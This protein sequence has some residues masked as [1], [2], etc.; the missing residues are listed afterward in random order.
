L[1]DE[2]EAVAEQ[3]DAPANESP[4][5]GEE[6]GAPPRPVAEDE[7]ARIAPAS[8]AWFLGSVL[9]IILSVIIYAPII[10]DGW[11]RYDNVPLIAREPMIRNLTIGG[12]REMFTSYHHDLYQPLLTLSLAIDYALNRRDANAYPDA[13]L[14]ASDLT[15]WHLHSLAIH[16]TTVVLLF[17]FIGRMTGN[18]FAAWLGTALFALHPLVVE[19]VSWLICRTFL[20]AGFWIILGCHFYLSYA[21][22]PRWWLYVLSFLC[23]GISMLAKLF[24]GIFLLPLV[25]DLWY[26]RRN[27]ILIVLDKL[28][29][30]ALVAVLVYF[31]ARR[32]FSAE[33]LDQ[34]P[35]VSI[36][37]MI[38]RVLVGMSWAEAHTFFPH[39]L[40]VFYGASGS[41]W[42]A[43]P[44]TTVFGLIM[45][46]AM[47]VITVVALVRKR[48]EVLLCVFGWLVLYVPLLAAVRV[49][50]TITADRYDYVP[51][52]MCALLV[53][54]LLS[55]WFNPPEQ[56]ET[57]KLSEARIFPR[58]PGG[59]IATV[60]I[61]VIC[62][63]LLTRSRAYAKVWSDDVLLWEAAVA[64][65]PHRTAYG[66]LANA[67]ITKA[68][69]DRRE[70][71][72][73]A[74][75][76]LLDRAEVALR[77]GLE[78]SPEDGQLLENYGALCITRADDWKSIKNRCQAEG[79]KECAAEAEDKQR[80][81]NELALEFY[82]RSVKAR[83]VAAS[84]W[85]G[86]GVALLRAGRLDEAKDALDESLRRDH[87]YTTALRNL[88]SVLGQIR[89]RAEA[90]A[91]RNPGP[92]TTDALRMALE[93]E[94]A[95]LD[96]LGRAEEAADLR[97]RATAFLAE[98]MASD[99]PAAVSQRA[100]FNLKAAVDQFTR[101]ERLMAPSR[102]RNATHEQQEQLR[103][104]ASQA[105]EQQL[106][107]ARSA[108][109]DYRQLISLDESSSAAWQGL[110]QSLFYQQRMEEADQAFARAVELDANNVEALAGW[111]RLQ[112]MTGHMDRAVDLL[113]RAVQVEPDYEPALFDLFRIQYSQQ[114]VPE[115]T[116]AMEALHKYYPANDMYTKLLRQLYE[117]QGRTEDAARLA[118]PTA[119]GE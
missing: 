98:P 71:D 10:R 46:A 29:I 27:W 26:R 42:S 18:V 104:A 70:G 25:F 74:V 83:P 89:R 80:Q 107:Y 52:F 24:M 33:L 21:R 50:E 69:V 38:N 72:M 14:P 40:S 82:Q 7:D 37:D 56:S 100:A 117:A 3:P 20:L 109:R 105:H 53:A 99:D 67:L 86:L 15:G 36:A 108:E 65:S 54:W 113:N 90:N 30:L 6:A 78:L 19:P 102:V 39:D 115:A 88:A 51:M 101:A 41:A 5:E 111:G 91:A 118:Q 16:L 77:R 45:M 103:T 48:I 9:L 17:L 28:P 8:L 62:G 44:A 63:L 92:A 11:T 23:F 76:D 84:A 61:L 81:R 94:A 43:S 35:K 12:V 96:H 64:R 4:P 93:E 59:W 13:D 31:N 2:G 75:A 87:R 112:A 22:R 79:N 47:V 58:S 119:P 116:E 106:T 32:M 110:A 60:L 55:R 66:Q 73:D 97:G 68:R 57:V 1:T 85:N 34:I 114:H 95:V 49:R